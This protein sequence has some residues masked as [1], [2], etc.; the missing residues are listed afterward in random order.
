MRSAMAFTAA[1]V[2][3]AIW[4]RLATMSTSSSMSADGSVQ[5]PSYM[6]ATACST[7][8]A[9]SSASSTRHDRPSTNW[10][11]SHTRFMYSDSADTTTRC[12]W[13][14]RPST[15]TS[16]SVKRP[17]RHIAAMLPRR[18]ASRPAFSRMTALASSPVR[19]WRER[20]D[21]I[22][23]A[24][25]ARAPARSGAATSRD[26]TASLRRSQ[27]LL[28]C[29]LPRRRRRRNFSTPRRYAHAERDTHVSARRP[30]RG[31][32]RRRQPMH[33][34]GRLVRR[35][36]RVPLR[37]LPLRGAAWQVLEQHSHRTGQTSWFCASGGAARSTPS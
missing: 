27:Q 26:F 32:A 33:A 34:P 37:W 12:M 31:R 22:A 5:R 21:V 23:V 36:L 15:T 2:R 13:R 9:A 18:P 3:V 10:S 14:L 8:S 35:R 7:A 4:R 16:R 24:A 6:K 20:C 29:T 17:S 30:P 28:A 25:S 19:L 11:D 1:S